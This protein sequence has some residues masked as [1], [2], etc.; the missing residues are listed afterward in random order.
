VGESLDS[1]ASRLGAPAPKA[2]SAVFAKW[3]EIVGSSVAAHT[4]PVSLVDGVLVVGV[5]QPAWASQLRFL[6]ADLCR[7]LAAVTG[8]DCV[9]QI[10]VQVLAKRPS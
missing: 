1:L 6:G 9:Q 8:D 3:G 10:E 4:W 7:Q 2:L 5:D